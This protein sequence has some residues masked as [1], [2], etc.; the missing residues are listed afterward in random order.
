MPERCVTEVYECNECDTNFSPYHY[1]YVVLIQWTFKVYNLNK[2]DVVTC[3]I[4]D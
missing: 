3:K 2:G 4:E 1:Q